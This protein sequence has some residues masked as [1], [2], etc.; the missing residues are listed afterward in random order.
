MSTHCAPSPNE[1]TQVIGLYV[2][3]G[4][5]D[6]LTGVEHKRHTKGEKD[7]GQRVAMSNAG[8]RAE[9]TF[10]NHPPSQTKVVWRHK[11]GQHKLDVLLREIDQS[12]NC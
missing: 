10:P 8:P 5:L 11:C 1:D 4:S 7:R 2:R 3:A 6:F 12:Q 9:D